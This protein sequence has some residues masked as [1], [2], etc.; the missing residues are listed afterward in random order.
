MKRLSIYLVFS[1]VVS[2]LNAQ[3]GIGTTTPNASSV[4]DISSTTQG[5]LA[6]R[7][8]TAQRTAISSPANGLLVY[9]TD[10]NAFFYYESSAWSRMGQESRNNYKLIQSAADLA[11]ELT[12]GGGTKYELDASTYY[13]V[14]GTISLAYPIDL[15]D[16]YISGLDANEDK[17]VKTGG[18]MFE[19]T[20]GG[21]AIRNLTLVGVGATIFNMTG[22]GTETL[23][24]QNCI[25][26]VANPATTD[27]FGTLST[28][29]IVFFNII[30]VA[31]MD[32][33]V[34][35]NNISNVLLSNVAWFETNGGTYETYTG[36]FDLIQKVSGF[37]KVPSGATGIDV[38]SDPTV[39][40]GSILAMPFSGAGTYVNG[41]TTGSYSGYY[42]TKDWDVDAPGIKRESDDAAGG[43]FYYDETFPTAWPQTVNNGTGLTK[44]D[45]PSATYT[46]TALFRFTGHSSGNRLIYDG[47]QTRSF[48]VQAS[49]SANVDRVNA[50]GDYWAFS[51]AKNGT[52]V[53]GSE[54]LCFLYDEADIGNVT[55][56]TNVELATN[57]YIEVYVQR[58]TGSGNDTLYI[59]SLNLNIQ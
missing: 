2:S 28:F 16:A 27:N 24:F 9:D 51:I 48:Q 55:I 31:Y 40:K 34:T 10:F 49:L 41:Y 13:E 56:N 1:F 42:F 45:A 32:G 6:P 19:S 47:K 5:M 35:F 33:G 12:A 15:N 43:G 18:N 11:D 36:T 50:S 22:A 58:I 57:D 8:T 30:N 23:L 3:V 59:Y 37:M 17:L 7:M 38:S 39:T 44:L 25:V 21:G 4:L 20:A 14:N 29:N 52:V 53:T 54:G 26:A 46:P